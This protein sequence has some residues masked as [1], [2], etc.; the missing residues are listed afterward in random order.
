MSLQDF[1]RNQV[2]LVTGAS[3]G[4]GKELAKQVLELG[5]KVVM[6]GRNEERLLQVQHEFE[7][8]ASNILIH[9]GDAAS[10]E[11][12][13][14]L[15]DKIYKRFGVLNVIINNAGMSG[16]GSLEMLKPEVAKQVIDTNIYGSVFP[17]M[18]A[19]KYFKT[20]LHSILFVSS[21]A[22]FHGLPAYAPYS[23]SKRSLLALAQS[24]RIELSAQKIFVGITHVGFTENDAQKKTLSPTGEPET[25]PARPKK[26]VSSKYQ[27]AR[28]I[29]IQVQKRVPVK[30]HSSFGKFIFLM[31][32]YFPTVLTWLLMKKYRKE[33][34]HQHKN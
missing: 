18:A 13:D 2:V 11:N 6:T 1:F 3:M 19:L 20:S 29:L 14:L 12:N 7:K 10:Y 5:G 25:I 23:L 22:G 28:K 15:M 26:L 27:T 31:G 24:L 21:I 32:N 17:V 33:G 30:T 4:I 34:R 9:A 16:Y 8:Y